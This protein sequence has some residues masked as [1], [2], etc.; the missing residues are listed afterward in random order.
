M[1]EPSTHLDLILRDLEKSF[2]GTSVLRG[3]SGH[4]RGG[5]FATLLG[6]SGSGKTTLLRILAGLES[7]SA[8]S[9]SLGGEDLLRLTAEHRPVN[10][11]FQSYA[12]FPHLDVFENVAFGLRSRKVGS[13]EVERRVRTILGTM[14]LEGFE[15]RAP[16][17]LSGGQKQRVALARALVN[18]PRVLL[19]D[20]PLS[21]VDGVLRREL[22]EE[23]RTLQRS[24]KTTFLM[25]THDREDALAMSDLVLLLNAGRVEQAGPP[26][27]LY[28]RPQTRYAARFLGRHN[29][30]DGR[31]EKSGKFE[32][33]FGSLLVSPA[34]SLEETTRTLAILPEHVRVAEG[35]AEGAFEGRIETIEYRGD[36]R[37]LRLKLGDQSLWALCSSGVRL[38]EGARVSVTFPASDLRVLR[39]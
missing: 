33:T 31:F 13:D 11:V 20:E 1:R 15:E 7:P 3:V 29:L 6:A 35:A 5:S 27:E 38:S 30:L 24:T 9:I 10:T 14:R 18:E 12:L 37:A 39:D 16:E 17:T 8:G 32:T 2:G 19:L 23:L 25:V 21:A 36:R 28:E 26:E 22:R 34:D 4:I